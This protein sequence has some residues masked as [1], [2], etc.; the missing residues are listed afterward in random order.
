METGAGR[1]VAGGAGHP[2]ALCSVYSPAA[3]VPGSMTRW[4]FSS[5]AAAR[6]GARS[7]TTP[8]SAAASD[9]PAIISHPW[10][11]A[12]SSPAGEPGVPE[13]GHQHGHAD[14]QA[15]L[16]QHVDDCRAGGERLRRQRGR[17]GGHERRQGQSHPD[18]RQ[19]HPAQH[20][21][22]VVGMHAD[23]QRPP[24]DAAGEDRGAGADHRTG[25]E[26]ADQPAGDEEREE[27][28]PS[29]ARER[30]PAPSAEPTS[31]TRSGP[32]ARPR[33]ASPRTRSRTPEPPRRRRRT[34]AP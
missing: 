16:A 27:R 32:R 20:L 5:L 28:A 18:A 9:T 10:R 1:R 14:R 3:S 22:G 4:S 2:A 7:N 12:A 6:C 31:P 33:A 24:G 29:A 21:A 19:K 25:A 34:S 11:K 30:R 15:D 8:A 26:A 13:H 17:A 23:G